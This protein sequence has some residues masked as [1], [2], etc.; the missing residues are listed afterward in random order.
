MD[1]IA[2]F[3]SVSFPPWVV[4]FSLLF[5]ILRRDEMES[6]FTVYFEDSFWI[7]VLEKQDGTG[8]EIGK[9]VFGKEPTEAEIHAFSLER[10]AYI[11]LGKVD[12]DIKSNELKINPKKMQRSVIKEQKKSGVGT[13]AQEAIKKIQEE[14]KELKKKDGK[15][16]KEIIDRIKFE[17]KA[18]KKKKKLKGH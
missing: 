17:K 7:G 14:K 4:R 9:V 12:G 11:V 13:K 16:K 3:M 5:N 10:Y 15:I 18:E 6:K 8:Y 1:G 2:W